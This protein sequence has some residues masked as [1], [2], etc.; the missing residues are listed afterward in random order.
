VAFVE[1]EER[2][3]LVDALR[4]DGAAVGDSRIRVEVAAPKT[5]RRR[6]LV[7]AEPPL[8]ATM[9]AEFHFL[10]SPVFCG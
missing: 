2:E 9:L 3:A 1:F 6:S 5:D 10:I 8:L 7:G 4:L